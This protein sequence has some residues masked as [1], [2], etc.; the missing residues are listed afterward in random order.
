MQK[1]RTHEEKTQESED[2]G[3]TCMREPE[4]GDLVKGA[5]Q[6]LDQGETSTRS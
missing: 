2:G 1:F 4:S 6:E 5:R 3:S